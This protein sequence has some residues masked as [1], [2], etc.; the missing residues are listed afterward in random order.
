MNAI[1]PELRTF[2]DRVIVPALLERL[3]AERRRPGAEPR[4]AAHVE[5]VSA[6]EHLDDSVEGAGGGAERAERSGT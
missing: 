6:I 1:S 3:L 4:E 5:S 2:V